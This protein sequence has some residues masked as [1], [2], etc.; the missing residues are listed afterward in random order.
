MNATDLTIETGWQSK[1]RITLD[2]SNNAL[3]MPE[4]IPDEPGLY[5]LSFCSDTVYFGE[6][7][8]LQRR[9]GDYIIYYEATGI[10]SEFRINRALHRFG[11][12]DVFVYVGDDVKSRSER[13]TIEHRL[14]KAAGAKALNGGTVE[15]KIS[16]HASEILRLTKKLKSQASNGG[17]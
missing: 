1:G 15:D 12:A 2:L 11:G 4:G 17:S 8:H 16:F 14:I 3:A 9:I 7:G 13:C 5:K 10:E 6:A